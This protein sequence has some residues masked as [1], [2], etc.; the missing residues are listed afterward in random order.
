MSQDTVYVS[1]LPTDCTE[2]DIVA[3]FR[4]AGSLAM[5]KNTG[6]YRVRLYRNKDTDELKGDGTIQYSDP[7]FAEDAVKN[8]NGTE[9]L[10]SQIKVEMMSRGYA[11]GG[12][13]RGGYGG[14]G[15]DRGGYG[16][17]GG[18][19]GGY[20]GGGDRGGYGDGGDSG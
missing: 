6:K 10:G 13:D 2:D 17:G 3:H 18:D 15:G 8:L 16:G 11:G 14:G 19:R 1:G 20:G 7:G 9:L 5:D 12:G 4:T